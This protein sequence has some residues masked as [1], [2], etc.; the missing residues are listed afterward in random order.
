MYSVH[1]YGSMIKDSVR[2]DAY[3]EALRQSILPESVVLEIGTG[4]G[5]MALLAAKWG[6]RRVYAIEQDA[7]IGLAEQIAKDNAFSRRIQFIRA[8]ST[9]VDLPEPVDV[10]VSDLRSALPLYGAHIPSIVDA[11]ERFLKDGGILIPRQD[12]LWVAPVENRPCYER[13]LAIWREGLADIDLRAGSQYIANRL[14]IFQPKPEQLLAPPQIWATLDY[15][16]ITDPHVA[17]SVTST[18]TR[19]GVAHGLAVWFDAE[20]LEGIGFSNAPGQ[21]ETVYGRSFFPWPEPVALEAGDR[22]NVTIDASLVGDGYTW[23]WTSTV[24]GCHDD[25]HPKAVF[26][27]S[28]FLGALL[29]VQDLHKRH[30]QYRPTLNPDGLAMQVVLDRFDGQTPLAEIAT[31]LMDRFP[32]RF[33][34]VDAALDYVGEIAKSHG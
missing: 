12:V 9:A 25:D 27:Q 33:K 1:Q 6:A 21:K 24:V 8:L 5:F 14:V 2:M 11:R 15:R 30:A 22:V 13:D 28:T 3:A 4:P 32:K 17:G 7:V 29:S 34:S 23:S 18:A 31:V 26:R 20:L 10:I 16:T 19:S